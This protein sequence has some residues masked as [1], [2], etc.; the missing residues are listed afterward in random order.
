MKPSSP[1]AP[2]PQP[3]P[4]QIGIRPKR[5]RW[6]YAVGLGLALILVAGFWPKAVPVEIARA[7][8]GS[9]QVTVNDQG[10]TRVKN[11]Y[12]VSS[13]VAG[14]LRRIEWKAGATVEAGK[15][16]LAYLETAGADLLDVRS[17]AQAQARVTATIAAREQAIALE[18]RAQAQAS[19]TQA[20]LDR[21]NSLFSRQVI[22]RE[23]LD[24]AVMRQKSAAAD[25]RA[26]EFALQ[27]AKGE[28][29][30]ARALL[31]RGQSPEAARAE[32]WVVTSP[33]TGKILRVFQESERTVLAGTPLMEVGDPTDLEIWI[34]VLSRDGVEIE[35]GAKV[36]LDQ[37]GGAEPLQARVR[38][39]EPSAWTKIS[40][41]GVEE[42][43]VW[44]IADFVDPVE[45]RPTLGDAYRVEAR[46]VQ[47]E[48]SHVLEVPAGALFQQHGQWQIF[49][50]EG[51]RAH[52]RAVEV[53]HSNGQRTEIVRGLEPGASVVNYPGDRVADGVRVSV[54]A[55]I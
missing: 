33:V 28:E 54:Q 26:A 40:A 37:W 34:E 6:P 21:A 39:V 9:L 20:E 49:V 5:Q 35:P 41:L 7:D 15:T 50:V 14:Q 43:R 42:Q 48:N 51:G 55:G 11:R 31:L 44:V 18:N 4:G 53:G 3:F 38:L 29:E 13:P 19:L 47:W 23:E 12:V 46:V 10:Q 16:P 30:Q 32:P 22:S 25:E 24:Q 2:Q 45:R 27:V 52:L 17:L 36:W 8:F 1:P